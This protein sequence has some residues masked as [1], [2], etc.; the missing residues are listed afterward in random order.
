MRHAG[1]KDLL[2]R[3][4]IK[5]RSLYRDAD[6]FGILKKRPYRL[7]K[8]RGPYLVAVADEPPPAFESG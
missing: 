1:N 8:L 6:G 3:Y 4:G 2:S 7:R 5:P